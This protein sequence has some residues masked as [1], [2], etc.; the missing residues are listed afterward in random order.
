MTPAN[1]SLRK[2]WCPGALR[3]M[4]TGDG[5]L[6]RIRPRAGAINLSGLDVVAQTAAECGSGEIDLT[7]RA[8]LQLR[9]LNSETYAGA[10]DRLAGAGLLDASA[11][12]EAIRNVMVDPLCD[13]STG[14]IGIRQLALQLEDRLVS[15]P[16]FYALPG[17]FG[18]S[19]SGTAHPLRAQTSADIAVSA[20]ES[21]HCALWLDGDK[22]HVAKIAA[23]EAVAAIE[24][25][26]AVF[27]RLRWSDDSIRRMRDAV[28]RH[29]SETIFDEAGLQSTPAP[30]L[31][32]PP[33]NHLRPG[34][35]G[36]AATPFAV[37]I[38]LPYGRITARDL[39]GLC[40]LAGEHGC[41]EARLSPLRTI[42][43]QTS[44]AGSAEA[45]LAFANQS[46][47]IVSGRDPRLNMDVCPGAPA[48]RNATTHTR[49]DARALSA[50]LTASTTAPPSVHISGCEKGCARSS[51]A[52]LTF[53]AR[54]GKYD[55]VLNGTAIGRA[56][57]SGLAPEAIA[58]AALNQIAEA[59]P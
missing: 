33:E 2:G 38:G 43:L 59:A 8:N 48:C 30:D 3:P 25:L 5:L 17:K 10:I 18:F 29:G 14:S 6:V 34:D 21:S 44:S 56:T 4:E 54:Q 20:L 49:D 57:E 12:A 42:V 28:A 11:E 22:T 7:S 40:K 58:A 23:T 52:A 24:R 31:S 39:Q 35:L 9:G 36:P 55:L 45:L 53:V 37:G 1:T 47:L 50:A 27:L 19:F 26:A 13:F 16:H 15:A 51:A 32:E 41:I 46:G